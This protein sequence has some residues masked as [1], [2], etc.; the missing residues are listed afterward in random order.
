MDPALRTVQHGT[1]V[2]LSCPPGFIVGGTTSNRAI[3]WN[4]DLLRLTN[5]PTPFCAELGDYLQR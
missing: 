5:G 2:M 3:C 4:G 1:E